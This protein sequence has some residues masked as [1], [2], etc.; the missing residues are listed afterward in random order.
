MST[1]TIGEA[2]RLVSREK[3]VAAR[4][5]LLAK[6]KALTRE[7]DALARERRELP[8]VRVD[9]EYVFETP[10]GPRTLA[11]LFGGR[12]QLIVYHFMF[13]PDWAEGCPSCSFVSDHLD[14]A[15]PHLAARDTSLVMVSRAPLTKI[16]AFKKRMGWRF[17]WVS[18]FGNSFN[19][20]FG[21]YF[22][23][24]EKAKGAVYYNYTTQPF[25]SDEAPGAS[26]FYKDAATGEV[27]HTYS[28]FGRGLDTLITS[29]V[30]LDLVPKGRDED[31]LPFDMQWVRHHDRYELGGGFADADQPY[32]PKVAAVSSSTPSTSTM[33][34]PASSCGCGS[35]GGGKL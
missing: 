15:V 16:D 23:P 7:H 32:W 28:T 1:A 30:L 9:Q 35:N 13:G 3:W 12:S 25:P 17:P 22:T 18:S 26:V 24:A 14:G 31:Q 8:W 5:A 21:V 4:V 2:H 20:D 33:A 10:A 34:A 27:F 29:Y 19:H 6:E 11:E